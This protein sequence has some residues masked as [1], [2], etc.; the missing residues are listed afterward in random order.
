MLSIALRASVLLLLA[1]PL[2]AQDAPSSTAPAQNNAKEL[3]VNWLY[4]AFVPKEVP[5]TSLTN[6]QRFKLY[7]RQTYLGWGPYLKTG[8]FAVGDQIT[9]SPPEWA[10]GIAGFGKRVASRHGTF[11]IQNTFSA[12]GNLLLRYEPRYDRCRC[13]GV[14]PRIRH[15]FVRNFVTYNHTEHEYRP[16]I[17]LYAGAM[18]AGMISSVWE[19]QAPA[20]W[21]V[22]YQSMI[23]QAAFG[24]FAN[25]AAEFA[26]EITRV[27]HI[28]KA[29]K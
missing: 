21:R 15:A 6:S 17:A 13:S 3:Q 26:P 25:L 20:A 4:G 5:F 22:G 9:N 19:P 28:G 11:T 8:F 23:T 10:G 12:T 24:S 2:L 18:G 27:L 16:Q 14:G 29:S 1:L 7:L